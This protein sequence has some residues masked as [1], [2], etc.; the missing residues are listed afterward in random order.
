MRKAEEET[1]RRLFFLRKKTETFAA[2]ILEEEEEEIMITIKDFSVG[3]PC[4]IVA[5]HSGRRKD[6]EIREA[7]VQKVGRKYVFINDIWERKYENHAADYLLENTS[8]GETTYLFRTKMEANN[9]VEKLQLVKFLC[10]LRSYDYE[11]CSLEELKKI[12]EIIKSS[13][14]YS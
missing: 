5:V 11:L 6:P 7:T 13:E 1:L 9:Y 12:V 14:K 10:G 3:A 4:Y 8:Y 2:G